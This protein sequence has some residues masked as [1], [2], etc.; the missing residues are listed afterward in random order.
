MNN[1]YIFNST[2]TGADFKQS[3]IYQ[4]E[5]TENHDGSVLVLDVNGD[6]SMSYPSYEVFYENWK[7]INL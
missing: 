3:Q 1:F 6:M 4:L 7:K 5:I 2:D